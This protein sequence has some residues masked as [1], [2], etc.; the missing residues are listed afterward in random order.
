VLLHLV[1]SEPPIP[2]CKDLHSVELE[3]VPSSTGRTFGPGLAIV[4]PIAKGFHH[5]ELYSFH[6][7]LATCMWSE[8]Q[9]W[10]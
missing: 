2:R 4:R 10:R 8:H 5:S 1:G 3:E 9:A 7:K 6:V